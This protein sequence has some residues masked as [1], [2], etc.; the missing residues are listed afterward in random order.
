[1]NLCPCVNIELAIF[2]DS[3]SSRNADLNRGRLRATTIFTLLDKLKLRFI[4]LYLIVK[5]EHFASL[6]RLLSKIYPRNGILQY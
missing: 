2:R 4:F 5:I 6:S 3:L 1:M